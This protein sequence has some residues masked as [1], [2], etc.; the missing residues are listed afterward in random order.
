MNIA[1][2]CEALTGPAAIRRT[3]SI[4][5]IAPSVNSQIAPR[6]KGGEMRLPNTNVTVRDTAM[7]PKVS[8]NV[9]RQMR[10][11]DDLNHVGESGDLANIRREA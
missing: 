6:A 10:G 9:D 4:G 5:R 1:T 8:R 3:S 2:R 7:R 11:Q